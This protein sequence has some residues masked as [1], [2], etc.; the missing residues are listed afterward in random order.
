MEKK[1]VNVLL[2]VQRWFGQ[3][4]RKLADSIVSTINT[5]ATGQ[6]G[7]KLLVHEKITGSDHP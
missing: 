3:L 7:F 4:V 6:F 1:I 5:L 2:N